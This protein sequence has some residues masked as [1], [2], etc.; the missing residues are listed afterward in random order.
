MKCDGF[1]LWSTIAYC[2]VVAIII[3][4]GLFQEDFDLGGG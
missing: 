2:F 4:K 3:L 1:Y